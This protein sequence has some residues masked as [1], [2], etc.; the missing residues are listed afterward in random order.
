MDSLTF[1][2]LV[3]TRWTAIL[4]PEVRRVVTGGL[5]LSALPTR[6][7]SCVSASPTVAAAMVFFVVLPS[8]TTVTALGVTML[9][10]RPW[11]PMVCERETD[12]RA[13]SP[14]RPSARSA[15]STVVS[16]V[17]SWRVLPS[18]V[19]VSRRAYLTVIVSPSLMGA[20]AAGTTTSPGLVTIPWLSRTS[21]TVLPKTCAVLAVPSTERLTDLSSWAAPTAPP[22]RMTAAPA[23]ARI[24]A[25]REI[26]SLRTSNHPGATR[27]RSILLTSSGGGRCGAATGQQSNRVADRRRQGQILVTA[28]RLAGRPK[29]CA[30][31]AL[32][33][34]LR[35]PRTVDALAVLGHDAAQR[36][37]VEVE[38]GRHR[39]DGHRHEE[40]GIRRTPVRGRREVRRV[41]LDEQTVEGHRGQRVP[42]VSRVLEGHGPREAEVVAALGA[43]PGHHQVTGEAVQDGVLGRSLLLED[44]QHVRVGI[45]VVDLEGLAEALGEVDVPAEPVLLDGDALGAGA[46]VIEAGL[47]DDADAVVGRAPLHLGIRL[48]QP[49]L[50]CQARNLVGVQGDSADQLVVGLDG[51][52][53]E[54]DA[55]EVAADL[56]EPRHTH[57]ASRPDRIRDVERLVAVT[58]D[59]EVDVVVDDVDGQRVRQGL[60]QAPLPRRVR[61]HAVGASSAPSACLGGAIF[62]AASGSL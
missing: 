17:R 53:G 6:T 18:T 58:R 55:V 37:D 32:P 50:G 57:R 44:A 21:A 1:L 23:A 7:P 59:V 35:T 51:I 47:T 28:P 19:R 54:T 13:P 49:A 46:E 39:P 15:P 2:S 45:A 38:H 40:R 22:V 26:T 5:T 12:R 8:T 3:C 36:R 30:L 4:A 56:D 11:R 16:V 52:H 41:G 29:K 61:R 62:G 34:S 10:V 43:L 33:D 48:R 42:Q 27:Y 20:S 9:T 24:L 14:R 31:G 25:L 60:R